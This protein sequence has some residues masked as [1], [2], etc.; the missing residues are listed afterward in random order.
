[1]KTIFTITFSILFTIISAQPTF[2]SGNDP[3]PSDKKWVPVENLSDE[4]EGD[5]MDLSKWQVD[6]VGN[7]WAWIGRPPGLF[8]KENIVVND[9]NMNVTV[10][11][12]DQP[13]TINGKNFTHQGAIIRSLKPG[14]VGWYFECKMKAN[15]TVM[16]STFWLMTKY[17][18]KKK[19]ETDIQEC[20]GR[21]TE[22]S[23]PWSKGWDSIFHS[24][25]IHRH[26]ACA[27]KLQLQNASKLKEP[28]YAR[29]YIYAAWWKSPKEIQFFLDGEYQYSINPKVEWD[30]PAYLH[31]AI[32]TYSWNPIPEDGGIV[33]SGTW[34]QR[35]TKYEWIRTWKLE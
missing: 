32:E 11:K 13:Q 31:M 16:S 12:L 22:L 34:E 27:E 17:N 20:V 1:M 5:K 2:K 26:T 21:T 3:K 14:N 35:T 29:Y 7:D 33:E 15:A 18:C 30:N 19:L 9:G 28:N 4:F 25:A 6:P 24:N 23:E 8:R 10:S